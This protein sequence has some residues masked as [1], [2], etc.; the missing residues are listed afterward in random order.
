MGL[1]ENKRVEDYVLQ[2][3]TAADAQIY[4][5]K[6][7]QFD[8]S[9]TNVVDTETRKILRTRYNEWKDTFMAGRPMLEEFLGKG[10]ENAIERVRALDDLSNM[11]DDPRFKNIRPETQN[12]LRDMVDAYKG[13]V[14][15]KDMFELIGG[16]SENIDLMKSIT[17]RK[18]KNL[19]EFN[20]NTLAAY[21]SIF[22]RLLGE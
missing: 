22:S 10:R 7:D 11:L 8:S 16:N 17:L 19:S 6:K 1:R 21:M 14:K 15:Q 12:V 4:Y 3:Q 9:V 5:D 13:Y 20:E 18:I 2:V